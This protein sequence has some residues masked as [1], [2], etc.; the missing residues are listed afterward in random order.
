MLTCCGW[1]S[2]MMVLILFRISS[3]KGITSPTCTWMKWRLHFWAILMKVSHAMSWTPSWVSDERSVWLRLIQQP[4]LSSS[5]VNSLLSPCMNSKS[6]LTTVL[7]NFQWALRKRGYWPT[8][9][10]MLEAMIALLSFPLFCSHKPSR[11]WGKTDG[12]LQQER[13]K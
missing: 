6:L 2:Q 13:W 11:S 5:V 1:R 9:Y 10:M 12:K 8:I 3:M 4:E 7:R